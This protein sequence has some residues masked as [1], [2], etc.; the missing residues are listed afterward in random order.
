MTN[1]QAT[2]F[3]REWNEDLVSFLGWFLQCMGAADDKTKAHQFVYYLQA[4]SDADEWFKDL[5][6]EKKVVGQ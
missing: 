5:E 3:R 1:Y 6:E 2:L 4:Y